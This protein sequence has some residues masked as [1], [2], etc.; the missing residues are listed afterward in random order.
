MS[1]RIDWY[2]WAKLYDRNQL[3]CVYPE[4]YRSESGSFPVDLLVAWS[5]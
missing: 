1:D 3:V 4:E 2:E 5:V